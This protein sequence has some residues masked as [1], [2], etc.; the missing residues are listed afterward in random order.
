MTVTADALREL[1][2]IHRQLTDLRERLDRGPKQIR[3]REVGAKKLEAALEAAQEATKASKMN[4]D[5]KHLDLKSGETKILDL[6]TKLNTCN[7]NKEYQALLD[8]I[9]A[10]EMAG[11][12]LS[13]EILEGLEEIDELEA[14]VAEA[15]QQVATAREE[16]AKTT[17]KVDDQAASLQADVTRL[18]GELEGAESALPA[19]FR[20][21]YD[22]VVNAKGEDSMAEV[23]GD[24]CGGCHRQLTPNEHNEL[25]LGRAVFCKNCGR[26]IYLP[27]GQVKG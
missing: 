17:Q 13:D 26:L 5:R 7:S 1:H 15:K 9:A 3:A 14:K 6:R 22:R 20:R 10:A 11:S 27:E 24:F 21:D 2:R 8:Q 12:V 16:L 19:D 18:E 25:Q 23:E 4:V